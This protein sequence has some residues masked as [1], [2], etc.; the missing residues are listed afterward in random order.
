MEI[1]KRFVRSLVAIV[2]AANI[3]VFGYMAWP[4]NGSLG[5]MP[6]VLT[7]VRDAITPGEIYR[8]DIDRDIVQSIIH[9]DIALYSRHEGH[10]VTVEQNLWHAYV[11]TGDLA[12][13]ISRETGAYAFTDFIH[14]TIVFLDI[15][16]TNYP[17]IIAHE[18]IH[19][20]QAEDGM[21]IMLIPRIVSEY[22]AEVASRTVVSLLPGIAMKS[23]PVHDLSKLEK[24]QVRKYLA[25]SS[26]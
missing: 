17:L 10:L 24:L 5:G 19:V 16:G 22:E 14:G 11:V 23:Y 25:G 2:L 4:S 9:L 13:E 20:L 15:S 7:A 26:L 21:R 1:V 3:G 8:L 12:R 6:V 18:F